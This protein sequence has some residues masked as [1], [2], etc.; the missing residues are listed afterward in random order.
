MMLRGFVSAEHQQKAGFSMKEESLFPISTSGLSQLCPSDVI[1]T[2][3]L[4]N[5]D[6][7]VCVCV[8]RLHRNIQEVLTV[9][10]KYQFSVR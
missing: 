5:H 1:N 4:R 2:K 6:V 8:R 3:P 9:S 7:C 10:C